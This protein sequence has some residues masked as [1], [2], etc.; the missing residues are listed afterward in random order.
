MERLEVKYS[1]R[2]TKKQRKLAAKE[3]SNREEQHSWEAS[4]RQAH[5]GV[6][7]EE[8]KPTSKRYSVVAAEQVGVEAA[9]TSL[10]AAAVL[11]RVEWDAFK[12]LCKIEEKKSSA[13]DVLVGEPDISAYLFKHSSLRGQTNR[14]ERKGPVRSELPGQSPLPERIR[15]HSTQLLQILQRIHNSDLCS[16]TQGSGSVVFIRPFKMLLYYQEAL[17]A[18]YRKLEMKFG[19][20]KNS[21][22]SQARFESGLHSPKPVASSETTRSAT[23]GTVLGVRG[24]NETREFDDSEFQRTNEAVESEREDEDTDDE[25]T[26][27]TAYEH[28]QCLWGF[29]DNDISA[30]LAYLHSDRCQKVTFSDLWHIFKPGGEVIGSDRKQAYRII[31]VTSTRHKVHD[32]FVRFWNKSA[33]EEETLLTI[34]CVY[35]DFDGKTLG[36]VT[37]LF[38]IRKFDGEKAVTSLEVYPLQFMPRPEQFRQRLIERGRMFLEVASVKLMY[39][40]GLTL[41]TKEEVEGQV[42]VDFSEA[43]ATG[44]MDS[45]PIRIETLIGASEE[46]KKGSFE[47]CNADCCRDENVHDDSYVEE[48]QSEKYIASLIPETPRRV[49]SV[50]IYPRL[51][52]E[53][54]SPED[55]LTDDELM[56]MSYRVFGFIFGTR[57]WAKLDLTYFSDIYASSTSENEEANYGENKRMALDRLVLPKGHKEMILSLIAQHFRSKESGTDVQLDVVR[58]KGKGLILLLHGA[59]GVGKTSTA[60]GVAELFRKPLFQITCGDLGSTAKEVEYALERSFALANR[61]GCILLLDEADVFLSERTKGDFIRNGL[62]SVFLRV[63]EY[64]AG[65]LFL[66]TNRIGDFDEA[67]YSRH[68]SLYYPALDESRT[69]AILEL[70]LELIRERFRKRG[71]AINIEDTGIKLF[72]TNYW[73]DQEKSRWNGRQIRNICQTALALA[74]FESQGGNKEMIVDPTSTIN[75][76]VHHCKIASDSYLEFTTYLRKL[77]GADAARRAKESGLR[78]LGVDGKGDIVGT[79]AEKGTGKI[80][81]DKKTRLRLAT[82]AMAQPMDPGQIEHQESPASGHTAGQQLS[83]DVASNQDMA[84]PSENHNGYTNMPQTQASYQ[85]PM[86]LQQLPSNYPWVNLAGAGYQVP[87]IFQNHPQQQQP[88][89]PP[90]LQQLNPTWASLNIPAWTNLNIPA[91]YATSQQRGGGQF[92]SGGNVNISMASTEGQP[93]PRGAMGS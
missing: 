65:I 44:G 2:R 13:I 80:K 3:N 58:G 79:M 68:I 43:F 34:K 14:A 6:S 26:S 25:T 19:P 18:W 4:D 84:I 9:Q 67:F 60:E 40:S 21:G 57:K 63:L 61:W 74:E 53:I 49:P 70:N 16:V 51:L 89:L 11:C 47:P 7:E 69:L 5:H 64:Y 86:L 38:H 32:P 92:D 15:I 28:L 41:D 23:D 82:Q 29:M 20:S 76:R 33:A 81:L 8:S 83:Q 85:G 48:K 77:F 22:G 31:K 10:S 88:F 71:I 30:K 39:Y 12:S 50:A 72:A 46:P 73:K 66:T 36:P 24:Q 91:S 75:L 90:Q 56:I 78:A 1:K 27:S 87:S 59:P 45:T 52:W 17:R 55:A 35:L 93:L 37:R 42:I 62:V 54:H